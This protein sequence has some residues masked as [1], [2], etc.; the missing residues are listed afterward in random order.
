MEWRI[1][2]KMVYNGI[3]IKKS[4]ETPGEHDGGRGDR[5]GRPLLS[6]DHSSS[7]TCACQGQPALI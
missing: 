7:A 5:A 1:K 4:T 2:A 6:P 3:N